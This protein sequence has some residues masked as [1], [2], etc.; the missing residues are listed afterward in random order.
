MSKRIIRFK[1]DIKISK[2]INPLFLVIL[3]VILIQLFVTYLMTNTKEFSYRAL[4][5]NL[6]IGISIYLAVIYKNL[7]FLLVPFILEFLLEIMKYKGY[8]IEKYIATKYQYNDYWREINKNDPIFSNFSEGNYDNILGFD[9]KDHSQNNLQR[10]LNWSRK[11]YND[12]IEYK[13]PYL[14]DYNGKKHYGPELKK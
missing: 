8:Y 6:S 2:K 3:L 10:I 14:I 4:I 1:K 13:M 12:S 11:V 5:R 7:L 9:T